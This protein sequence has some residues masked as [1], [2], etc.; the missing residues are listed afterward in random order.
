LAAV[1]SLNLRDQFSLLEDRRFRLL[2]FATFASGIGNWLALIALQIDVY[3]RTHSGWWI[4]ALLIAS[5]L[6]AVFL[7]LL[8]GPLVDRLSRKGLMIASDVGRLAI[9]V[10]L[11][12]VNSVTAI[13]A[14]AALAGIGTAF[15]RPA[16]LAGLPNLVPDERLA[17][18]NALLQL[19][20]WT[21]TA[22]GPIVGGAIVAASGPDIAYW[23][24]AVTFGISALLVV[25]IPG[26]LLQS[27]RPIGRG[28]WGELA[29]GFS[30][31]RRSRALLCVLIA[32]SIVMVAQG[33]VNVAEV[34]LAKQ[35]YDSGAFGFGLLWAGSGIGLV[36]G[37]LASASLIRGGVAV[38][39]VRLL[40]LFVLGI[41]GAA[42][43]PNVWLGV[44]AM[45]FAGFGNGG[46]VVAN[47][48]L[49]QRGA[50][51]R[52]RGRVFTLLMSV[53]YAVLGV[54]FVLAGPITD[55]VGARWAYAAAA[56]VIAVA[57]VAARL[58]LGGAEPR[59]ETAPR[60][61]EAPGRPKGV[62][63]VPVLADPV[64]EEPPTVAGDGEAAALSQPP[65]PVVQVVARADGGPG[66]LLL[67]GAG[68]VALVGLLAL[69]GIL[70]GRSVRGGAETTTTAPPTTAPPTTSPATTVAPGP[71][72]APPPP[73]WG[74]LTAQPVGRLAIALEGSAA[75]ARGNR[76]VVLGG[77]AAGGPQAA[78]LLG[79]PRGIV[80]RVA[81][82]PA[83]LA[84]GAP[85][86][87]PDAVY[88][89]GGE[90]GRTVSDGIVR[91]DLATRRTT[92][93]GRF[94][95]PLAGAGHAQVGDSLV[96][97][98][99]WTG[100]KL[101]TG[102]LRYSLN[103]NPSLVARLPEAMRDPAVAQLGGRV[104]VAGGLTASG[105]SSKVYAVELA[106]GS[107]TLVGEL[108]RAVS[109]AVLVA[110]GGQ[111]YL[112]GGRTAGGPVAA[113]VH[114][115]PRKGSITAAGRMPRPLASAAAVRVGGKTLVVGGLHDGTT[116]ASAAI[117]RLS[118]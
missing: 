82:L 57:L 99:G 70:V 13:I 29:E 74:P 96:L 59:A 76:L 10:A 80:P 47:I 64:S 65:P 30:V 106:S 115:D 92:F 26:R 83:P 4:G 54:A 32:W 2:F 86:V 108:P 61:A 85:L 111:L 109:S 37:G 95:E 103:G 36:A 110:L 117:E 25:G 77:R 100:E 53:N 7:G 12:F 116:G 6:P 40:A 113:V 102:V 79:A 118:G 56:G 94:F 51:D 89:I 63:V 81:T 114:I 62:V 72:A 38:A 19:V 18:A 20:E 66:S 93:A 42:V 50:E 11:P 87:L 58:I 5:I 60:V 68:V 105:P 46:A 67:R 27:D 24:N 41:V 69:A 49:V 28:H 33:I 73:S 48:T 39:Y 104:Y 17:S 75:A 34:F 91:V 9:F 21:T 112:L 98:G 31:V 8:A 78:V 90:R 23:V 101:A 16:V 14:L 35:S 22:V 44:V 107:V 45:M 55:T 1:R 88:L 84:A 3:D 52:V 71:Q 43:A 15:F 97:V